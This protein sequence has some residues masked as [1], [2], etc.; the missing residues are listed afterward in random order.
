MSKIPWNKTTHVF[1]LC[2]LRHPGIDFAGNIADCCYRAE[3]GDLS[4]LACFLNS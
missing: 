4:I 3:L 2:I 1:G